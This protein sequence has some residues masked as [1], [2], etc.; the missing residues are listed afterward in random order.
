MTKC[1]VTKLKE[2]VEDY[3][4]IKLGEI[5]IKVKKADFPTRSSQYLLIRSEE[6]I[7]IKVLGGG[8][9]L[10][11]DAAMTSGD[12]HISIPANVDTE[13]Y[14]INGDYDVSISNKYSLTK[15]NASESSSQVHKNYG[16]NIDDLA[17][18][19]RLQYINLFNTDSYGDLSSFQNLTELFYL[20]VSLC[21]KIYGDIS[22]LSNLV[23][24][25]YVSLYSTGI[26][27]DLKYLAPLAN[28]ETISI[29][30]TKVYGDISVLANFINARYINI[31]ETGV[32][33]NIQSLSRLNRLSTISLYK[34]NVTGDLSYFSNIVTL[35]YLD[36]S[37]TNIGGDLSSL[38]NLVELAYLSLQQVDIVGDI[39]SLGG[40]KKLK[41]LLIEAG[42]ITGSIES[43][44]A[45]FRAS[46]VNEGSIATPQ[47][48][49]WGSVTYNSIELKN[50]SNI[51]NSTNNK[52]IWTSDNIS[53][54]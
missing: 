20:N 19:N 33:G 9:Y 11:T 15:I 22:V 32:T 26:E 28:A 41:N 12:N 8:R 40:M 2:V 37:Y 49:K 6:N 16:L 21:S 24:L 52:L 43:L 29:H 45:G 5:R 30:R 31:S 48:K 35:S 18:S 44:I 14:F 47:I 38:S 7:D 39:D 42:G 4:L 50:D 27:G 51:I 46:G 1:L 53:I 36:L 25:T 34:L 3:N 23:G 13:I 17:Y 10:S 54:L